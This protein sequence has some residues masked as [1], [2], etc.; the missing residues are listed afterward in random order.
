[1]NITI[2][3]DETKLN[4][5]IR[6]ILRSEKFGT[7]FSQVFWATYLNKYKSTIKLKHLNHKITSNSNMI[8]INAIN[9]GNYNITTNT[10]TNNPN[11]GIILDSC[12][13]LNENIFTSNNNLHKS[14][15]PKHP[16]KIT[17]IHELTSLPE[18]NKII[19]LYKA[20]LDLQIDGG[21]FLIYK[22]YEKLSI[23]YFKRFKYISTKY[24]IEL[25]H[26][27]GQFKINCE[28]YLEQE[29]SKRKKSTMK[30]NFF[31]RKANNNVLTSLSNTNK[32]EEQKDLVLEQQKI[33][34]KK[35]LYLELEKKMKLQNKIYI[36]IS[37]YETLANKQSEPCEQKFMYDGVLLQTNFLQYNSK[38]TNKLF[39]VNVNNLMEKYKN[40]VLFVPND[41]KNNKKKAL[42]GR[43]KKEG[44]FIETD[45]DEEDGA[46]NNNIISE[47]EKLDKNERIKEFANKRRCTTMKVTNSLN[48]IKDSMMRMKS[49]QNIGS[50][51]SMG[52]NV[53]N[54]SQIIGNN[55]RGSLLSPNVNNMNT[56][57]INN[58]N[59]F[60]FNKNSEYNNDSPSMKC[61]YTE[62]AIP[63]N[64]NVNVNTKLKHR[65][66]KKLLTTQTSKTPLELKLQT[67]YNRAINTK[68]S[69]Q[70]TPTIIA[71][72]N[73]TTFMG[74]DFNQLGKNINNTNGTENNTNSCCYYVNNTNNKKIHNNTNTNT[75]TNNTTEKMPIRL[76]SARSKQ[77][78][79]VGID[80]P[81]KALNSNYKKTNSIAS[82][83]YNNNPNN[84]NNTNYINDSIYRTNINNTNTNPYTNNNT[85]TKNN[86]ISKNNILN[87][88]KTNNTRIL[89]NITKKESKTRINS[90][91]SK[92]TKERRLLFK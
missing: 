42:F 44:I 26:F 19:F 79:G 90:T 1:M 8:E 20:L 80:N 82:N 22:Y 47:F 11:D 18:S 34:E 61:C 45:Y 49:F 53:D 17:D 63:L 39:S 89:E 55:N 5:H 56:N 25:K 67:K 7:F 66:S 57:N 13:V 71:N 92:N 23:L 29:I 81:I 88:Y 72:S 48:N 32:E 21:N 50:Y 77:N 58:T 76:T 60:N 41:N 75:N 10:Y 24:R 59:H 9:T 37:N 65:S 73:K 36:Y 83:Y 14:L 3:E 38:N 62:M 69:P 52:S 31:K 33:K 64:N 12:S 30:F 15:Y 27:A 51:G 86:T 54:S 68:N 85:I 46:S 35:R 4:S 91:T 78:L 6:R 43:L 2:I 87:N 28:K 40:R 70:K 74:F 16:V 84:N